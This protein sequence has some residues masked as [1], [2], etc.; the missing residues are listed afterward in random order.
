MKEERRRMYTTDVAVVAGRNAG[1][2]GEQTA[3]GKRR[4]NKRGG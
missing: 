2:W 1:K 3:E 4:E